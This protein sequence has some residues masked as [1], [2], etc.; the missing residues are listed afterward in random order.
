MTIE[1]LFI[2][3]ITP[4]ATTGEV[5][6]AALEALAHTVLDDGADGLVALGTTGEPGSLTEDEKRAVLDVAARVARERRAPLLVGATPPEALARPEITAALAVVPSFVRP[7]EDGVVAHFARLAADSPV[8]VVAY[9]IPYRTGQYLTAGAL[10]RV[11]AIPGVVG[12]KYAGGGVNADTID[13]LADPPA[14]FAILGG[15]DLFISPLLALGA[16]GGV[17]SSAHVATADFAELIAAWRAG[18]AATARALGH[19][20]SPLSAA[21]F[22]EPNPT[23]VKGVLHARGQ[24]PTADVRLPLLAA[25]ETSVKAALQRA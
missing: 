24:I 1:G 9:D 16:H 17:L 4:F 7:G 6:L 11:A 15:D 12:V 5:D 21:L 13:L 23:V 20:L 2:P 10:R 3:L 22:A 19:R 8:P 18:D 25:G 14:G